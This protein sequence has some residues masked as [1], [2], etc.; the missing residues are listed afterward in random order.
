LG[1][2]HLTAGTGWPAIV[3]VIIIKAVI[4]GA[5][6]ITYLSCSSHAEAAQLW[7]HDDCYTSSLSLPPCHRDSHHTYDCRYSIW[8]QAGACT[9]VIDF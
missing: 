2:F 3:I 7:V 8:P 6:T 1:Q 5:I 4:I 9:V